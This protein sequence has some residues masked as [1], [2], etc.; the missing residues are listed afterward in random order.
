MTPAGPAKNIR[1]Y[2]IKIYFDIVLELANML[3]KQLRAKIKT[4]KLILV[5]IFT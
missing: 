1:V 3:L 5:Y 4:K 2:N